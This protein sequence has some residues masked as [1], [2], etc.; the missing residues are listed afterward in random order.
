MINKQPA[1]WTGWC[2]GGTARDDPEENTKTC[3]DAGN[4]LQNILNFQFL[5]LLPFR[6]TDINWLVKVH[7]SYGDNVFPNLCTI[8]QIL[9]TVGVSVASCERSF[10]KL[11]LIHSQQYVSRKTG[12]FS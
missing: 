11:K 1:E 12:K 7:R 9:R 5:V 10:S 8:L 2:T 4:I 3:G 6:A